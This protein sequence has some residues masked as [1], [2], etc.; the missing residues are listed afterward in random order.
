MQFPLKHK[1][2]ASSNIFWQSY[3]ITGYDMKKQ[4]VK[5]NKSERNKNLSQFHSLS[6]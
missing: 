5:H 1:L 6:T 3:E 4:D 2:F